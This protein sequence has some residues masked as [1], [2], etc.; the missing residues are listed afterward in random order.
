ML[1]LYFREL[2][3]E[4]RRQLIDVQQIFDAWWPANT[5]LKNGPR[6]FWNS[7][8]GKR[9]LYEQRQGKRRSLGRETA[10]LVKE[11]A[12]NDARVKALR[13]RV[14]KLD[15]RVEEMAPI[16]KAFGIAR[17]PEIAARIIRELDREGLLGPHIT[18]AGTNALHAYEAAAGVLIVGRY[19]T[20]ADAD[21]IW[22]N[23]HSLLLSAT[24][25]VRRDGL[26]SILRRVDRSFTADYGMVARNDRGYIVDLIVPENE[27]IGIM[28]PQGDVEAQQISG[29]EWLLLG[30]PFEQVVVGADGVPLRMVVPEPRTFALH[31]LWVSRRDDRNPLKSIKDLAHARIVGKVA[32]THLGLPLTVKAMSWLPK[33]LKS[34]IPDLKKLQASED[35]LA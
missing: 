33:E 18:I 17:V 11:K 35:E 13:S 19:T 2:S 14:R 16:N 32:A 6:L 34:L 29:I 24:S 1:S 8:K 26:M 7:S 5:D 23:R 4:Q 9:Y 12:E 31:K 15:G 28:R 20:T 25:V 30:K 3:E 22:D 21:L 27:S 10:A